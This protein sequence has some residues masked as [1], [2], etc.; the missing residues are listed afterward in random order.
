MLKLGIV[1]F[2]AIEGDV[3]GNCAHFEYEVKRHSGK[4]LDLLCFPEL[5]ISG[6]KFE[7]GKLLD[8]KIGRAHV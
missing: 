7:K 5:C 8:E 4:D 1:Q 3:E 6:Y 2:A